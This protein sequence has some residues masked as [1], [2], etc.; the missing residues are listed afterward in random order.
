MIHRLIA[1]LAVLVLGG[2]A[3]SPKPTEHRAVVGGGSWGR[4]HAQPV[5]GVSSSWDSGVESSVVW[6]PS[7][8]TDG[9]LKDEWGSFAVEFEIPIWSAGQR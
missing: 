2:C 7:I 4:N 6:T 3:N 9:S 8:Y 5:A 1:C